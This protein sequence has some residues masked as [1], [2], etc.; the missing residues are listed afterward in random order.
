LVDVVLKRWVRVLEGG[1]ERRPSFDEF[2]FLMS[3]KLS[4]R[5]ACWI[6]GRLG[7]IGVGVGVG[8]VLEG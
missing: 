1:G 4:V 7:V 6:L 2:F 8:V 3:R 5:L